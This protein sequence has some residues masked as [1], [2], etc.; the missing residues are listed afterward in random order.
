LGDSLRLSLLFY[1]IH[2]FDFS[3]LLTEFID[4]APLITS[5]SL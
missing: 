3:V 5:R 1:H 4:F 2:L